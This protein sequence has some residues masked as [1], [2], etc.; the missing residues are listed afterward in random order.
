MLLFNLYIPCENL[1][2]GDKLNTIFRF[3]HF[4][5]VFVLKESAQAHGTPR[6]PSLPPC[7]AALP[8]QLRAC[9]QFS[10]SSAAKGSSSELLSWG[11]LPTSRLSGPPQLHEENWYLQT[12]PQV[13]SR[14]GSAALF[15]PSLK[16]L[17]FPL[18]LP[19][20][21]P[22]TFTVNYPVKLREICFFCFWLWLWKEWAGSCVQVG[23][24]SHCLCSQ[25]SFWSHSLFWK[26]HAL[27]QS[28]LSG[29]VIFSETV[30]MWDC[31]I[32]EAIDS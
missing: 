13:G 7:G 2:E 32:G 10:G 24:T 5:E 23:I 11:W 29:K 31:F 19:P 9:Y 12:L 22:S 25:R 20:Q 27:Q 26:S 15:H 28:Y 1:T 30:Y 6:T 8:G 17:E 3:L 16:K 21:F 4:T 14:I 18:T